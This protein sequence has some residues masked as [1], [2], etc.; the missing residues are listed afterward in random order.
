MN[1]SS[2]RRG[3]VSV[4]KRRLPWRSLKRQATGLVSMSASALPLLP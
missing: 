4:W 2:T 3:S 1:G